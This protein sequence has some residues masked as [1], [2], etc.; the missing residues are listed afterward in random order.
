MAIQTIKDGSN[1]ILWQGDAT[2]T[3]DAIR[4]M[5]REGKHPANAAL[6]SVDLTGGQ[7]LSYFSFKGATLAGCNLS[8]AN[9]QGCD[10]SGANLSAANLSGAN[11]NY[12]NLTNANLKGAN[13]S[14]YLGRPIG[15]GF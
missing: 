11:L 10:L 14:G 15:G 7:D 6:T 5:V 2:D 13:L 12:C 1:N 8:G 4:R 9:L 3:K